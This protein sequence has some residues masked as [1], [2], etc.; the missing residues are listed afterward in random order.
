MSVNTK[1]VARRTLAFHSL[2][3]ISAELD[4]LEAAHK[5]GTLRHSGNWS[6]GQI[7][8]HC[9]ILMRCALDGFP[10]A[11]APALL[12]WMVALFF[13][14]KAVAGTPPAAGIRPGPEMAYLQ[15]DPDITFDEGLAELRGQ[16]AR[17]AAGERFTRPSPLFGQLTHEQWTGIQCGHC[18][19]HLS[20]LSSE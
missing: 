20:F 17:V 16:L 6:A 5:A 14:R 9:A 7:F 18:A 15:P 1:K 8:Q 13:K 12:R 4:R 10:S 3:D 11:R 2:D 19:L